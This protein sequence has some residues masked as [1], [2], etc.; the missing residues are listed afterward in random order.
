MAALAIIIPFY[1]QNLPHHHQLHLHYLCQKVL[2]LE[3]WAAMIVHTVEIKIN[4]NLHKKEANEEIDHLS[5]M[6]VK[7]LSLLKEATAVGGD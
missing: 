6:R 1:L 7:E 5:S 4:C 2:V 3:P